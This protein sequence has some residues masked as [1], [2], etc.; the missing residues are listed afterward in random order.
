MHAPAWA[1]ATGFLISLHSMIFAKSF[2]WLVLLTPAYWLGE[3]FYAFFI[4]GLSGSGPFGSEPPEFIARFFGEWGLRFLLLSLALTPLARR[5][6]IPELILVRRLVGLFA[7]AYISV[8]LMCSNWM[9]A[10]ARRTTVFEVVLDRPYITVGLIA[11]ITLL[12]FAVTST[13]GWKRRPGRNWERL[14]QFIYASLIVG[15][16]HLFWLTKE[17]FVEV[18]VYAAIAGLLLVEC[19]FRPRAIAHIQRRQ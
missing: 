5:L 8:H 18:V 7:L 9:L 19:R 2:L 15:V 13:Q 3:Q 16:V 17:G 14:Q 6:D 11:W 1:E 10:V 12:L 4:F